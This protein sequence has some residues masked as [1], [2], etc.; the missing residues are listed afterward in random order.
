MCGT[1]SYG[2]CPKMQTRCISAAVPVIESQA[3]PTLVLSPLCQLLH[4][5][6]QTTFKLRQQR[7]AAFLQCELPEVMSLENLSR[8]S[9]NRHWTLA[10]YLSPFQFRHLHS[11]QLLRLHA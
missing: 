3:S 7:L 4:L 10:C 6:L 9:G 8:A 1:M 2:C 5:S 11:Q